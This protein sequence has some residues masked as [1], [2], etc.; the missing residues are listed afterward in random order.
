MSKYLAA[1]ILAAGLLATALPVAALE[2][3]PTEAASPADPVA[4]QQR[5][6]QLIKQL[7]DSQY[8][9][10][11][12]A[13]RELLEIGVAAREQLLAAVESPDAEVR[14]RARRLLNHVSQA[15]FERQLRSFLDASD[16]HEPT[17]PSWDKARRLLGDERAA[18]E[19]FVEMQRSE[20]QLLAA[21][22]RGAEQ[23]AP[24]LAARITAIKDQLRQTVNGRRLQPPVASVAALLLVISDPKIKENEQMSLQMAL[25]C[26]QQHFRTALRAAPT[27]P[28]LEPLVAGWVKKYEQHTPAVNY[29]LVLFS[30][31][32]DLAEGLTPAL[33]LLSHPDAVVTDR[34]HLLLA[35]AKLGNRKELP[36]LLPFLSE[37]KTCAQGRHGE[38]AIA[39][40]LRDVALAAALHLS[41]Q[42]LRDYGYEHA[43]AHPE[44]LYTVQTLYFE[45]DQ[46]RTEAFD[47]WQ[48]W[49]EREPIASDAGAKSEN[50]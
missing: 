15:V 36:Y 38:Q 9:Q 7:G 27:R 6:A 28:L 35:V 8:L 17:L 32:H 3:V 29:Q 23:A 14:V 48:K 5:I 47:R 45:T 18:R 31:A 42:E 22:D 33:K 34:P 1:A 24:L 46:A 43:Q 19:L 39:I 49:A 26:Y 13:S 21:Y 41:G 30:A 10:R 12:L 50:R 44:I 4:V 11:E 40:Q 25:L 16:S 20:R 37:T 2:P